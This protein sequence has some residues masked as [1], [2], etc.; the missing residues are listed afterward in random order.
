M[1]YYKVVSKYNPI[2]PDE[3]KKY[4]AVQRMIG[5]ITEEDMADRISRHTGMSRGIVKA[6]LTDVIDEVMDDI[7]LGYNV[8][9]GEMGIFS[10]GVKTHR[11]T[12][13]KEDFKDSNV[14]FARL[15]LRLTKTFKEKIKGK[16]KMT[17]FSNVVTEAEVEDDPK[18][19]AE[20][21]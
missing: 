3:K 1:A 6:V 4:Y 8:R 17:P 12:A 5:T 19:E 21:E 13:T 9:L 20:V 7:A 11:A 18:T 14:D 15:R 16:I 2:K 10:L